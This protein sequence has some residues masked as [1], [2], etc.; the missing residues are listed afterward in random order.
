MD[1]NFL[2][3]NASKATENLNQ[4][5]E[6]RVEELGLK[7]DD[8]LIFD[9]WVLLDLVTN[10][11]IFMQKDQNFLTTDPFQ[12]FKLEFNTTDTHSMYLN[13]RLPPGKHLFDFQIVFDNLIE[14]NENP[15]LSF[16][17]PSL[18]ES[19]TPWIRHYFPNLM[20]GEWEKILMPDE[21]NLFYFK[22]FYMV[23]D[24]AF[25]VKYFWLLFGHQDKVLRLIEK[26]LK[27]NTFLFDGVVEKLF[28]AFKHLD[29]ESNG[30]T[31]NHVAIMRKLQ[32]YDDRKS[33]SSVHFSNDTK[34]KLFIAKCI[35]S[36]SSLQDDKYF[37]WL[38][39]E[40]L[41]NIE[42]NSYNRN[43]LLE[44]CF[45]S[46]ILD[47]YNNDKILDIFTEFLDSDKQG[48]WKSV[49]MDGYKPF[50]DLT[51]HKS[52]WKFFFDRFSSND[53]FNCM[54]KQYILPILKYFFGSQDDRDPHFYFVSDRSYDE[55]RIQT[56]TE[57]NEHTVLLG[58]D[59]KYFVTKT[60]SLGEIG[61]YEL[62]PGVN[63]NLSKCLTNVEE[64]SNI[65]QREKEEVTWFFFHSFGQFSRTVENGERFRQFL[66]KLSEQGV[67][68]SEYRAALKEELK[69]FASATFIFALRYFFEHDY[70]DE[71]TWKMDSFDAR[72]ELY[73]FVG[74]EDHVFLLNVLNP[75]IVNEPF[76]GC[77]QK[78]LDFFKR[79]FHDLKMH[80]NVLVSLSRRV[81]LGIV[82]IFDKKKDSGQFIKSLNN[83]G[84]LSYDEWKF[85]LSITHNYIVLKLAISISKFN[86]D[87]DGLLSYQ[88]LSFLRTI[89]VSF[90]GGRYVKDL[91]EYCNS[92][93]YQLFCSSHGRKI[94]TDK[95]VGAGESSINDL[96][97]MYSVE[98]ED[99]V[100]KYKNERIK[101]LKKLDLISIEE[102]TMGQN[103]FSVKCDKIPIMMPENVAKTVYRDYIL[104]QLYHYSQ[105]SIIIQG[106]C[107]SEN[108][109]FD[110][111]I[112]FDVNTEAFRIVS[113]VYDLLSFI[114]IRTT[115]DTN[116]L[117][118]FFELHAYIENI[119]L[120]VE[121]LKHHDC[122]F[123]I[124]NCKNDDDKYPLTKKEI[125][126][127]VEHIYMGIVFIIMIATLS[128]AN[129]PIIIHII[130]IIFTFFTLLRWDAVLEIGFFSFFTSSTIILTYTTA[131]LFVLLGINGLEFD[132]GYEKFL[133]F[134]PGFLLE[135]I[136]ESFES[137][138]SD[139]FYKTNYWFVAVFG[140]FFGILGLGSNSFENFNYYWWFCLPA[141]IILTVFY[142]SL[143]FGS[144]K[145]AFKLT[146][147]D[148]TLVENHF[149]HT[150][151]DD[152]YKCLKLNKNHQ[153]LFTPSHR[154]D[155]FQLIK[156]KRKEEGIYERNLIL[157]PILK[158]FGFKHDKCIVQQ[159]I[160]PVKSLEADDP[161]SEVFA[162][163]FFGLHSIFERIE[164]AIFKNK[165]DVEVFL[166][167]HINSD[168]NLEKLKA[169]LSIFF[170]ACQ[171]DDTEGFEGVNKSNRRFEIEHSN[172]NGLQL[173]SM[174]SFLVTWSKEKIFIPFH[175]YI[176]GSDFKTSTFNQ[177]MEDFNSREFYGAQAVKQL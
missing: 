55:S 125:D 160:D 60:F 79:Y 89:W 166:Y 128:T 93:I 161:D 127:V 73:C 50:I 1:V 109:E 147:L 52:H 37:D 36:I 155:E 74:S 119:L 51:A 151:F 158:I 117:H 177:K 54:H 136:Q 142:I 16:L 8:S 40:I 145:L 99:T 39:H 138:V 132:D 112:E 148:E 43:F 163:D 98:N 18:P 46:L 84:R 31:Y 17:P 164:E 19:T 170:C 11:I 121:S 176:V 76:K 85:I 172:F 10:S 124:I 118:E 44:H 95:G 91:I 34:H 167:I 64:V 92:L 131:L 86:V 65:T 157:T 71:G 77:Y 45:Q 105:S 174:F 88:Q 14:R 49:Q 143:S 101:I 41:R 6:R 59:G 56:W 96:V 28:N 42:G 103:S 2:R 114:N 48:Y 153:N 165:D 25:I 152:D 108:N 94:I 171:L 72:T 62:I 146:K 150:L 33:V 67:N 15:G 133:Y 29:I 82:N 107:C 130:V 144:E 66:E 68:L 102:F 9:S 3:N 24:F 63:E 27:Y 97:M 70:T 90:Y 159:Y 154:S 162:H 141:A 137:T 106:L 169:K 26:V 100:D 110:F 35:C 12:S 168:E 173:N 81:I 13:V 30:Y 116:V 38:N 104:A 120:Y 156:E 126:I 115:K 69:Y 87:P 58:F 5:F 23:D 32:N 47:Y 20:K 134:L 129:I 53:L 139:S 57:G 7:S 4:L 78:C 75:D 149:F 83:F 140:V 22:D 111:S 175:I 80:F 61:E 122:F 113:S 123:S 21:N 135:L